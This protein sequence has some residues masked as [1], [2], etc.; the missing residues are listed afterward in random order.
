[1]K[2]NDLIN[3]IIKVIYEKGTYKRSWVEDSDNGLRAI[4]FK[5]TRNVDGLDYPMTDAAVYVDDKEPKFILRIVL[6]DDEYEECILYD[7]DELT[8]ESLIDIYEIVSKVDMKTETH[9]YLPY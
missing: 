7:G 1:M 9:N 4:S 6:F 3:S 2:T 5:G 8:D